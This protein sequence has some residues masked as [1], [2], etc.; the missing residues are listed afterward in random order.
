MIKTFIF[1]FL[2]LTTPVLLLILVVVKLKKP[3][4]SCGESCRCIDEEM[5]GCDASVV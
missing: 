4:K 2:A 3:F 1:V 5:L